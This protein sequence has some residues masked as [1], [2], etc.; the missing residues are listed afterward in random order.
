MERSEYVE[1]GV[2]QRLEPDRI[3]VSRPDRLESAD[4]KNAM[5]VVE[6][7]AIEINYKNVT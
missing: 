6:N 5:A 2:G 4:I 7:G 1:R 3:E